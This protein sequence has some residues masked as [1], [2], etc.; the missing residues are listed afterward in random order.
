MTG[1]DLTTNSGHH[2]LVFGLAI[3][4]VSHTTTIP[5]PEIRVTGENET[6]YLELGCARAP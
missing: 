3:V 1:A 2:L 6:N 5:R 4:G